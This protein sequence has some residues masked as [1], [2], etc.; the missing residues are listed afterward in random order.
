MALAMSSTKCHAGNSGALASVGSRWHV[1]EARGG[2]PAARRRWRLCVDGGSALLSR[3]GCEEERRSR[4]MIVM[5]VRSLLRERRAGSIH[6]SR[7]CLPLRRGRA[8]H[9]VTIEVSPDRQARHGGEGTDLVSGVDARRG[10][11]ASGRPRLEV[12]PGRLCRRLRHRSPATLR[13]SADRKSGLKSWFHRTRVAEG[14]VGVADADGEQS[15]TGSRRDSST[16]GLW[17]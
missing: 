6:G 4:A 7:R 3:T 16:A 15:S 8:R 10:A 13:K 9:P 1:R 11:M 2:D 12:G 17:A 14:R 5:A